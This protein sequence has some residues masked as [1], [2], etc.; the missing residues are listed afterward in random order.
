[1]SPAGNGELFCN[2]AFGFPVPVELQGFD[3]Q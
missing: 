3:V 2:V 1:V